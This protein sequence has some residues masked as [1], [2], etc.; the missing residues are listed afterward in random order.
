MNFEQTCI[1]VTSAYRHGAFEQWEKR[2]GIRTIEVGPA[3]LRHKDGRFSITLHGS[4]WIDVTSIEWT[5]GLVFKFRDGQI[6][7]VP[8]EVK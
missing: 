8:Q 5:H 3:T 1:A 6:Y 4:E 7:I 2:G